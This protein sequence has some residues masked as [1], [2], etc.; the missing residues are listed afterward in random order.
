MAAS[1]KSLAP[2]PFSRGDLASSGVAKGPL[3][4]KLTKLWIYKTGGPV[5]SSAVLGHGRA[6]IGS[7]DGF[8]HAID[9][10]TGKRVWAFDAGSPVQAPP[11]IHGDAIFVGST[12]GVF[13]AL[14]RDGSVLWSAKTEDKVTGSATVALDPVSGRTLVLVGSH[15]GILQAFDVDKADGKPVWQYQI[16]DPINGGVA[17]SDGHAVFGGCDNQLHVVSIADGKPVRSVDV[18]GVIACSVALGG[19]D[20]YFGTFNDEFMRID[21]VTGQVAW[22]FRDKEF[23]YYSSAAVTDSVVVFG[24]EDQLIHGL[25]RKTGK[26]RWEFRTKARV[27]SSPVVS[28]DR[29][30]VG[31]HD[32]RLYLLELK[33]GKLVDAFEVGGRISGSPGVG[34]NLV[35]VGTESNDVYAFG[36][37]P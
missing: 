27:D 25:D 30:V 3:P 9:L 17:I 14:G 34:P 26:P 16:T 36:K 15:A 13:Y 5:K 10:E 28:G 21:T 35:V 29:V 37:A 18:G 8:V 19:N 31:S 2:W 7:D 12:G 24:G 11:L 23:K 22:K 32:G 20:A 33:T 4:A 1:E 6:Y